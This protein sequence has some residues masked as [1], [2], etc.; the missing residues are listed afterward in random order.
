MVCH[1]KYAHN[2]AETN[3]LYYC[4]LCEEQLKLDRRHSIFMELNSRFGQDGLERSMSYGRF[5][6]PVEVTSYI[7]MY[8]VFLRNGHEV[9]SSW[10]MN[11]F[12][13]VRR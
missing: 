8:M 6:V 9:S 10:S 13:E 12:L 3:S 5:E 1:P 4:Y 7:S 11:S 2:A